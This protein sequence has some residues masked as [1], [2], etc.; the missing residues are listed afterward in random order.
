MNKD[1]FN[2]QGLKDVL[3]SILGPYLV[4]LTVAVLNIVG[5]IVAESGH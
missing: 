2:E 1:S 4:G 5:L 3:R